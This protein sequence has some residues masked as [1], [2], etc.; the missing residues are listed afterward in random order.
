MVSRYAKVMTMVHV[1]IDE[2]WLAATGLNPAEVEHE[3]R[4]LLATKL[5]ELR[6]LTLGQAAEM[7]GLPAW[8][9]METLS[10]LGVSVV[11]LTDEQLAH[12]FDQA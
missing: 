11:N 9:F 2:R 4:L 5:F 7:A 3:F 12:E 10:R 1:P 6:R 8:S